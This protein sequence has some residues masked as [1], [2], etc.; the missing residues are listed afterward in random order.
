[1]KTRQ[2]IQTFDENHSVW[3]GSKGMLDKTFENANAIQL[4]FNDDNDVWS[5]ELKKNEDNVFFIENYTQ[6]LKIQAELY[7]G[8]PGYSDEEKY[9]V[10]S[11]YSKSHP[12]APESV[13]KYYYDDKTN[14]LFMPDE[15]NLADNQGNEL[16]SSDEDELIVDASPSQTSVSDKFKELHFK[17]TGKVYFIRNAKFI[18]T[19]DKSSYA[20]DLEA[21]R[22]YLIQ[23]LSIIQHELWY[24][25]MYGLP[26]F[27]TGI[28]KAMIDAEVISIINSNSAVRNI[29]KFN[30]DLKDKHNYVAVFT[31]NTIYG[32]IEISI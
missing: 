13:I 3:F 10:V 24:N 11:L 28:T 2:V 29:S 6:I 19:S 8:N 7:N 16:I 12:L 22:Q 25:Y 17:S 20:K 14:D 30:S 5:V 27:D 31:V 1:M 4:T 23:H 21:V 32:D 15:Y 9:F 26:L 18:D